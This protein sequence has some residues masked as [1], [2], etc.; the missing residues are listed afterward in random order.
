MLQVG[1]VL[2]E[3]GERGLLL[4]QPVGVE[5]EASE[6]VSDVLARKYSCEQ[7]FVVRFYI[8]SI[9]ANALA[10]RPDQPGHVTPPF[11]DYSHIAA[12]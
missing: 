8:T 2:S 1:A 6:S 3:S 9:D 10:P 4:L 7:M 12:H 5:L 11:A